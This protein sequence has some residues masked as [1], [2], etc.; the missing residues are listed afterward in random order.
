[1]KFVHHFYP[2]FKITEMGLIDIGRIDEFQ[3][4]QK[5][6]S[7]Q[8]ALHIETDRSTAFVVGEFSALHEL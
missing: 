1:M 6:R 3:L 5:Y 7:R 8:I 4:N 2:M